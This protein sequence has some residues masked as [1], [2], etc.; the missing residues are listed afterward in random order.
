MNASPS[1]VR[2]VVDLGIGGF[3]EKSTEKIQ[4]PL[5]F[6]KNNCTI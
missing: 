4:V 2:I 1:T 5:K 3:F 6:E